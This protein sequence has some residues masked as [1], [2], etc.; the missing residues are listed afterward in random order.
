MGSRST[1]KRRG[2]NVHYLHAAT[3]TAHHHLHAHK[4][5]SSAHAAG[6]SMQLS[7]WVTVLNSER[8]LLAH[9]P[10]HLP[11]LC[12]S[13]S[14]NSQ[15]PNATFSIA[16]TTITPAPHNHT[17]APCTHVGSYVHSTHAPMAKSERHSL[18]QPSF[19]C[20]VARPSSLIAL[21]A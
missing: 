15:A 17:V 7:N 20:T 1:Q 2:S 5:Q 9:M 8:T 6:S 21:P 3:V 10:L 12:H 16:Q 13:H 4:H 11:L 14:T 19:G 18:P